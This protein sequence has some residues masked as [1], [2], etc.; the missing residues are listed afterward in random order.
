[1]GNPG[2]YIVGQ[3]FSERDSWNPDSFEL[4]YSNGTFVMQI[5]FASPS[6]REIECFDSGAIH[7]GLY[8]E[9]GVTFFLMK[10]A[11]IM[12]WCDQ[13]FSIRLLD[14]SDQGLPEDGVYYSP[15]HF[16]L[17]DA[18]TGI[19]KSLRV[20]TMSPPFVNIFRNELFKQKNGQFVK[21]IH[22][23]KVDSIY[24]KFPDSKEM[25]RRSAI[26]ERAGKNL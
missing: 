13:A 3:K 22:F 11:G 17:V 20:V 24:K 9:D 16:I 19:V 5:N 21:D 6:K 14:E 7:I 15:I 10:I 12:G 1:M 23:A 4:R 18:N 25:A 8:I 26:Q 2:V